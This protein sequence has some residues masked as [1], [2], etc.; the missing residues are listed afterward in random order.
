M[1]ISLD[2]NPNINMMQDL[3]SAYSS[4]S[5]KSLLDT[6]SIDQVKMRSL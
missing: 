5:H 3:R 4:V 1:G 6:C 2:T